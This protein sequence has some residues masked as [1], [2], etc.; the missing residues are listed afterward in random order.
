[1]K[2][3]RFEKIEVLPAYRQVADAIQNQIMTGKIQ[4]GEPIGTES[5]LVRQ[6]GVNRSTVREGIRLLEQ[7]G[8]LQRG[9]KRC[10]FASLPRHENE[11]NR[12]SRSLVLNK[13]SFRELVDALAFL[14]PAAIEM[15]V[16]RATDDH[17]RRLDENVKQTERHL[18]HTKRISE[19]DAEFHAIIAEATNNKVLMLAREPAGILIYP[20]TQHIFEAVP[21]GPA[22]LLEAHQR[23]VDSLRNRDAEQASLWMAKHVRD[24]IKGLKRTGEDLDGPITHPHLARV[25]EM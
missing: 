12:I 3:Q 23:L 6:F 22:R 8:M 25:M 24:F 9:E 18:N 15:A 10:L 11:A 4:P 7:S 13:V 14:E 17:I 1:M 20:A 2:Q 5:D 16:E 19:L 21:E